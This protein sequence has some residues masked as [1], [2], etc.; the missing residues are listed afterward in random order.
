LGGLEFS[1]DGQYL[2][3]G[4]LANSLSAAIYRIPLTRDGLTNQV[5]AMGAAT[6]F[7]NA[8]Q[9]DG[10]LA[11]SSTGSFL[12][13]T[14]P[15]NQL[16]EVVSG[17]TTYTTLP[18]Q[19]SSTGGCAFV[20]AG[21]PNAGQFLV[22]SYSNGDLFTLALTPAGGGAHTPGALTLFA[23]L[24]TGTE[25]FRI[26]PSGNLAGD[27]ML[28]N[29]SL[30]SIVVMD[31]DSVTGLPVGG[32][33]NP[34]IATFASGIG[35]A[36]GFAFDPLTNDFFV[37]TYSG[38]PSNSIIQITGFP[39]PQWTLA[40]P[41]PTLPIAGGIRNLLIQA[42]TSGANRDY[43]VLGGVSGSSPG[44]NVAFLSLPLNL[45]LFSEIMYPLV[46]TS[47]FQNFQGT[48]NAS[49]DA[50]LTLDI[51]QLG[52]QSIGVVVTFAGIFMNPINATSIATTI[53]IVP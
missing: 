44:L 48:T 20:P 37:S 11:R 49:G 52:A 34:S 3:C 30:A 21:F 50:V 7:A 15:N 33:A 16:G 2:F 46:N 12:F 32:S 4:G 29:Y 5:I 35:G 17:V 47:L 41:V 51:P 39:V 10:G 18:P 28:A 27:V 1:Q 31:L 9:I 14:Y 25:G 43:I 23:Q 26:I 13:T 8:A 40:A 45:D 24:P 53:T 22:S 6:F 36:E 38:N 42:G 19:S